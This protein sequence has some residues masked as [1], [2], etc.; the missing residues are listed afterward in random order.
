[1]QVLSKLSLL[2]PE[3][4]PPGWDLEI[5][6]G[7]VDFSEMLERVIRRFEEVKVL[8]ELA[9]RNKGILRGEDVEQGVTNEEQDME[10]EET[11]QDHM[12][13]H[14][15]GHPSKDPQTGPRGRG[16]SES[17]NGG[18]CAGSRASRYVVCIQRVQG[19][20]AWYEGKLR[21]LQQASQPQPQTHSQPKQN[22]DGNLDVTGL[23]DASRD[24]FLTGSLLD[25]LDDAYW[26]DLL[27]EWASF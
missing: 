27:G 5:V 12:I 14:L 6:M 26:R 18:G 16:C 20:K 11:M 7:V 15:E 23:G 9:Q 25:N 8:D 13:R 21:A 3:N 10:H 22:F 1:M 17:M 4:A 2:R 24:D 19:V